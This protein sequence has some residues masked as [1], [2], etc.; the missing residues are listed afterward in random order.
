MHDWFATNNHR[1]HIRCRSVNSISLVR[2]R[3]RNV[4]KMIDAGRQLPPWANP[5]IQILVFPAL[6]V[7]FLFSF[8]SSV[9]VILTYTQSTHSCTS[10]CMEAEHR[11]KA[12]GNQLPDP[13]ASVEFTPG[14]KE[15]FAGATSKKVLLSYVVLGLF[16]GHWPKCHFAIGECADD[17]KPMPVYTAELL[18][19]MWTGL[20]QSLRRRQ[21]I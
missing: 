10:T 11:R 9:P 4:M 15:K 14:P 17:T 19:F 16:M 8:F 7:P 2:D 13:G 18:V 20:R 6:P 12:A 5:A 21:E 1:R 3:Q